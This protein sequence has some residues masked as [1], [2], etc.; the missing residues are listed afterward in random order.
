MTN[1]NNDEQSDRIDP[2]FAET[3][4]FEALANKY[5]AANRQAL[6]AEDAQSPPVVEPASAP[7]DSERVLEAEREVLK[8]R[9]ELENFRKR[10]QRDSEQ[11][12]K[13]ANLPLM[14][15]LL[16][17]VDNLNRAMDVARGDAADSSAL[18]AGVEMVSQQLAGVLE[19]FGCKPVE[20]AGSEFDPNVHEAISQMPSEEHA[21]GTVAQEVAVGYLLHDRVVRPSSVIVSTGPAN[22]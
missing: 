21:A 2:R 20:A 18:L 16:D 11:Q 10:M 14:R 3:V 17:V 8:A 6:S 12:L 13:Y 19:K 1:E 9:A 7:T 15:D 4:D 5:A 22:S